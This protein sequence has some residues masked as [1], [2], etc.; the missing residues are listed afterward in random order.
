MFEA[1]TE[2]R[3]MQPVEYALIV[4]VLPKELNKKR[5]AIGENGCNSG[6]GLLRKDGSGQADESDHVM[7]TLRMVPAESVDVSTLKGITEWME[8]DTYKAGRD[9]MLSFKDK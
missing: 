6:L 8:T 5:V 2:D 7:A 3:T 4:S 9:S 1:I